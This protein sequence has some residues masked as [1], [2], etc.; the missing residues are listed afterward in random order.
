[1]LLDANVSLTDTLGRHVIPYIV[2]V[3]PANVSQTLITQGA[4]PRFLATPDR[5]YT[6][7]SASSF[8]L[9][10]I[11]LGVLQVYV[12]VMLGEKLF[13]GEHF[14]FTIFASGTRK[15]STRIDAVYMTIARQ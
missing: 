15:E 4:P 12:D 9:P 10:H 13:A 14:P 6:S 3:F 2:E 5:H 11:A 8:T 7:G 1:M